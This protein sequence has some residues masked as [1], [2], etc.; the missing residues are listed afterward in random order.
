MGV[1][2]HATLVL[3]DGIGIIYAAKILGEKLHGKVAGIEFAE[4][5]I[6]A[7]A[8]ENMRLYLLGAKPG[9]AEKAGANLCAKYPGL[10]LAGTHDGY[11]SDPQEVV[12]QHQRRRRCGC[13]VRLS[14]CAQAGEIHCGQHGR[15]PQHTVSAVSAARWMCLQAFMKRAPDIFI[16]LGLEWFYRLLKPAQPYQPYDEAAGNFCS[17][18]SR[19]GFRQEGKV[20]RMK[21][22]LLAYTPDR[23]SWSRLQQR[24][25]ISS[26]DV[27]SVLDGLTEEKTELCQHKLSRSA[28]SPIEHVSFTF[29]IKGV[30][31]SLLAQIHAPPHRIV[32]GTEPAPCA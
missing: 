14:G 8:K 9:V 28:R 30:S 26:T 16:K 13:C 27:E 3:P 20:I 19:G 25:T 24:T 32:L 21:V 17:S 15:Y 10:V 29:A 1:V 31:R 4:S 12:D 5:L 22:K 2:N 6:A 18:L 11:F 23:K 7:M